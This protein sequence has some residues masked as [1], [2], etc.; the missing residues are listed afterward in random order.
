[1]K[2]FTKMIL[3]FTPHNKAEKIFASAYEAGA[4]GGTILVG[5]TPSFSKLGSF[6]AVGDT[7]TDILQILTTE[8]EHDAIINSITASPVWSKKTHGK[9]CILSAGGEKNMAGESQ[10]ITVIVN[11]GFA[12]DVMDAARKAGATGGT[13]LHARGTGKPEDE[14]FF[15]I[16]IVPEKEQLLIIADNAT[17][18][19]IKTAISNLDILKEPGIGIIFSLPII[20]MKT[21]GE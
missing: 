18:E 19:K 7:L 21:L 8:K 3:L 16:T 20:E 11:R 13:I 5:S 17:A 6:F 10:L 12:N 9:L 14:K 1:M 4:R 15:G 2:E